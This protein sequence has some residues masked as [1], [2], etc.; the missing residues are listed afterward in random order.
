MKKDA[1]IS[2]CGMY[3]YELS[4]QWDDDLGALGFVMLNPSTADA[5][6]DDPTIRKCVGF[7]QRFGYGG[8]KVVNL[9]AYRATDPADL[10]K[11][12]YP[13]GPENDRHIAGA[14]LNCAVVVCAWGANARKLERPAAVLRVLKQN[15]IQP[16]AL[17][18]LDGNV[19]GHPLMLPYACSLEPI[20]VDS[21]P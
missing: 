3:R 21:R 13:I 15:L 16:W 12:G 7:A 8:I 14:M 10:K 20:N 1:T 18:L 4:R 9:F 6:A 5:N 2:A 11:A 19:P 17:R